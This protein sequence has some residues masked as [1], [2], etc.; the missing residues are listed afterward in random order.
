MRRRSLIA[1]LTATLVT[2]LPAGVKA[3]PGALQMVMVEQPGCMWC[4][5]WDREIAPIWPKTDAGKAAP[6]R[7]IDLTGP[8]PDDLKLTSRP[9]LTPTFILVR[10][11]VELVRLEG[12]P[13][14][15]F[16][17]PMAEQMIAM[18]G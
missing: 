1:G 8:V 7:R 16:F 9:R 2:G 4:D 14:Q 6:L 17:W 12:Y 10:G 18:A 5:R 3:S 11:G 13:G 15:D